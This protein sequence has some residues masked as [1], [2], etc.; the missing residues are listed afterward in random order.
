MK[1]TIEECQQMKIACVKNGDFE[2]A[3]KFR[4]E[5]RRLTK[6]LPKKKR[7]PVA[8]HGWQQTGDI[9]IPGNYILIKPNIC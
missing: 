5:E 6:K 2:M 7:A 3:L 9:N 8:G 1:F 4:D